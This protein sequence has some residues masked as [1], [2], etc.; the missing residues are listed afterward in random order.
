MES[1]NVYQIP[2]IKLSVGHA[3]L[4]KHPKYRHEFKSTPRILIRESSWEGSDSQ[5]NLGTMTLCQ[6]NRKHHS[7]F[8]F[9]YCH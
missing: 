1:V 5:C 3:Q 4:I 9:Y 6:G 2:V 8:F 7:Q